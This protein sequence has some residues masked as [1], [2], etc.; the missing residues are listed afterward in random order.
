MRNWNIALITMVFAACSGGADDPPCIDAGPA[1]T[2]DAGVDAADPFVTVDLTSR[3]RGGRAIDVNASIRL[4]CVGRD[5]AT[6]H[7]TLS[8]FSES[9]QDARSATVAVGCP[10]TDPI[11]VAARFDCYKQTVVWADVSVLDTLTGRWVPA[12]ATLLTEC[13]GQ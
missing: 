3:P 8:V 6:L 5:T 11:T 4:S 7:A 12:E 1:P 10:H 2:V 13:P 9:G